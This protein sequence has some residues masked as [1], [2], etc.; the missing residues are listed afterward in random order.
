MSTAIIGDLLQVLWGLGMI[1]AGVCLLIYV[2]GGK[3]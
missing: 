2:Y 1:C 3:H